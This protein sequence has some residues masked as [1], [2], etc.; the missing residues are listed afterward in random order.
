MCCFVV[1]WI[2]L[3]VF[4]RMSTEFSV[5]YDLQNLKKK[6]YFHQALMQFLQV[7]ILM[8]Y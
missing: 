1:E 7:H 3:R 2:V 8:C 5:F 4:N 6:M